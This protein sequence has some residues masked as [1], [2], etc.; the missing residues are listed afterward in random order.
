MLLT[1]STISPS[2]GWNG[3]LV[4]SR[5]RTL[6]EVAQA[7]DF[8]VS[9]RLISLILAQISENKHL[10]AV[11]ED[12]LDSDGSEIYLKPISSYIKLGQPQN[13]YTILE[14]AKKKDQVAFGYRIWK[15]SKDPERAY[16]VVINPKKSEKVKF[17][18]EDRVIVFSE[19]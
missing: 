4:T 5:N 9:D 17:E 6:A 12:I 16:G 15:Y 13:F 14:A 1:N 8:V 3:C 18:E 7:D 10:G 19:A 11:F 2:D